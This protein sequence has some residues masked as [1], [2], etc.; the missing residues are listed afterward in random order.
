MKRNGI[1]DCH[2]HMKTI[3]ARKRYENPYKEVLSA[4]HVWIWYYSRKANER[5]HS[6]DASQMQ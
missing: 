4:V 1:V 3:Q 5:T 6:S 2:H